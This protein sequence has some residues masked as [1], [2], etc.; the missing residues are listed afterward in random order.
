VAVLS[1]SAMATV[2]ITTT[3]AGASGTGVTAAERKVVS[4]NIHIARNANARIQ[5][6]L[7]HQPLNQQQ[8]HRKPNAPPSAHSPNTKRMAVVMMITTTVVA[9]GMAVIAVARP[10]TSDNGFTARNASAWTLITK[11][12]VA[13]VRVVRLHGLVTAIVMTITTTV[14]ANM[15][16]AIAVVLV[17]LNTSILTAKFASAS[18]NRINL[19][20]T[21]KG[22]V[23]H[24]STRV[25]ADAMTTTTIVLATGTL[26]TAVENRGTNGNFRIARSVC[27][28]TQK[29]K[30]KVAARV[31]N[32]AGWWLMSRMVV[33][34]TTTT[35]AAVI[36]IR[37][38]VAEHPGTRGNS[39]TV[40]S[41][42]A[43]IPNSRR[44]IALANA[45]MCTTKP[46]A[47]VTMAT[48]T[49]AATGTVVTAVAQPATNDSG[50]IVRSAS[51]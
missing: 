27:A 24:L 51:V 16:A 33:A 47:V 11:A 15:M 38:T 49:A 5:R 39:C 7:P 12:V 20:L 22:N 50:I 13:A 10:A 28:K 9:V 42:N 34:T 2:M 36:G 45:S 23:A 3:T 21:A 46:M 32:N 43:K 37:A 41:A 31:R 30:R 1:M 25:T 6:P 44:E 19:K 8:R 17:A 4:G 29:Q 14:A 18:T 35:T 40:P 26:A 48:T